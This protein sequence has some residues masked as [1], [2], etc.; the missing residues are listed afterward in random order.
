MQERGGTAVPACGTPNGSAALTSLRQVADTGTISVD[1]A[2]GTAPALTA[3]QAAGKPS[4]VK[5]PE[6]AQLVTPV[7]SNVVGN[8]QRQGQLLLVVGAVF[9]FAALANRKWIS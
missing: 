6:T 7:Q 3:G 9:F 8:G 1:P 2:R 5:Q 4:G